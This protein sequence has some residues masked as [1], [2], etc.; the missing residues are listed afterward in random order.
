VTILVSLVSASRNGLIAFAAYSTFRNLAA[1]LR[2][3]D[4]LKTVV[5]IESLCIWFSIRLRPAVGPS[6]A[7][8]TGIRVALPEKLLEVTKDLRGKSERV[9]SRG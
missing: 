7:R 1:A 9:R 3:S 6:P 4:V 8:D 2:A 5:F